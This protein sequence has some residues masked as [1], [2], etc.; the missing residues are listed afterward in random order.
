MD[1]TRN[2]GLGGR[3]AAVVEIVEVEPSQAS[4]LRNLFQFYQYDF[5]EIEGARVG[6]DGRFHHLE[7]VE[8]QYGY[9]IRVDR[10]L[11]GFAL[12]NR[13]ASRL[14]EGEKVWW[15]EEF[16]VMRHHRRAGVGRRAAYLVIERHPGM[17]ELTET[18]NN[19]SAIA[20]WRGVLAR[21]AYEDVEYDDP[22]W[23][24]RPLQRFSTR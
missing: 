9:F 19:G 14:V 11:A 8:F 10:D 6:A 20:F 13:K 12:V 17:W 5:S 2:D 15:M 23:G 22:K 1:R 24:R 3:N 7:D 16:F 4:T 18:P 21:Y